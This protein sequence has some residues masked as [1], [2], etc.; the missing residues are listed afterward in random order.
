[1]EASRRLPQHIGIIMDGNGRWA[2]R[3]GLPRSA[4]HREGVKVFERICEYAADLGIP[5]LTFYAFSAENW[6]RPSE[7]VSAIMALFRWQLEE[8]ERRRAENEQKRWRIR[9]IG[10]LREGGPVPADILVKLRDME[11]QAMDKDKTV[12]NI[13]VNYSGKQ[14]ILHALRRAAGLV[15]A[16][17][18][19]PE[20]LTEQDIE[21]GLYTAGQPAPDLIIRP[22]GELRLSNFLLWQSAYAELWFS[23]I[24]W[25]D[26]R[27]RDLEKALEDFARRSRRFGGIQSR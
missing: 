1:M 5:Y 22:S 2:K 14:E 26:F 12:V 21:E 24:L 15:Q 11:R 20:R 27:E 17:V 6:Q 18:L 10:D 7:E 13:A 4:G 23:D 9:Y 19:S 3:R 8:V 16:G 25:P